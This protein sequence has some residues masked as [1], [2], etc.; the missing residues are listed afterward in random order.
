MG[1]KDGEITRQVHV[2]DSENNN[3]IPSDDGTLEIDEGSGRVRTRSSG[4]L[5]DEELLAQ[6]PGKK[7]GRKGGKV[8]TSQQA[9]G[10][11]GNSKD[12]NYKN[13]PNEN[14]NSKSGDGIQ[15]RVDTSDEGAVAPGREE[16]RSS[17][18]EETEDDSEDSSS[19][20]TSSSDDEGRSHRTKFKKTRKSYPRRADTTD[21]D[22]DDGYHHKLLKQNPGLKSYLEKRR[23]RKNK[24]KERRKRRKQKRSKGK[25][26]MN[27]SISPSTLTVYKRAVNRI[28]QSRSPEV[29]AIDRKKGRGRHN[30]ADKIAKGMEHLRLRS[31][32]MESNS[33]MSFVDSSDSDSSS[34]EEERRRERNERERE[35]HKAAEDMILNSEQFK[36]AATALPEGKNR[37]PYDYNNDADFMI[38]TCHVDPA[39]VAKIVLGKYI[40]LE[41]LLNKS[42][43]DVKDD[44][45][46]KVDVV[47]RDGQKYLVAGNAVE[48][49]NKIQ[50]VKRWDQAFKVYM[51]IYSQANPTRAVEILA[52]ADIIN[53]AA[54]TFTWENVAMYDFYFRRLMDK[55]PNRSWARTHNQL[56][57][58]MMK[59]HISHKSSSGQGGSKKSLRE[60]CCWRYNRNKCT[61]GPGECK[62]EHR[63][64]GCG[65]H[66][67]IYLNCPKRAN[68]KFESR[69]KADKSSEGKKPRAGEAGE[70]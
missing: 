41:K 55:H 6:L 24:A 52:Y 51:M 37:A 47:T 8:K 39:L 4:K 2:N 49:E 15:L 28:S 23:A 46:F 25:R 16:S 26:G 14:L 3:A 9:I 65:S 38:S 12:P 1:E 31:R 7:T 43:R 33:S 11:P 22:S 17:S 20:S 68:K 40:A 60:I 29:R 32:E 10:L 57:T 62:F 59:D 70:A 5:T 64:S 69:E 56:W 61:R 45:Q 66:N 54:A 21:S 58:L 53:N 27:P 30:N 63:C 36:A 19:S 42:L 35:V 48:K 34:D 18:E 67:H 13:T 50:S 44:E